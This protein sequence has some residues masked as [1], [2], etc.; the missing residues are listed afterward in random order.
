M[1]NIIKLRKNYQ[2]YKEKRETIPLID[3][4]NL[5]KINWRTAFKTTSKCAICG[6]PATDMHHIKPL[7][8]KGGRYKGYK[9]FDKVVASLGR[10]QIPTCK[11]CHINIHNGKYNGISLNDIYD[12]RL[13]TP[14]NLLKYPN[15]Q[16]SIQTDKTIKTIQINKKN[17]TYFN[18]QYHKYLLEKITNE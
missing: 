16:T 6:L 17:K 12:Y 3:F 18:E 13:I 7:N 5:N 15:N 8:H 11:N 1:F 4:A 14:E 2:Q 10:K 9:G